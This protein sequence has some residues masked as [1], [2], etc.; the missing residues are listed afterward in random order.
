VPPAGDHALARRRVVGHGKVA[1]VVRAE[2]DQCDV[3]AQGGER[4]SLRR[5]EGVGG[6][7]TARRRARARTARRSD[8]RRAKRC[9]AIASTIES[10][11]SPT[12]TPAATAALAGAGGPAAQTDAASAAHAP[13]RRAWQ[14]EAA[15]I[16]IDGGTPAARLH[17]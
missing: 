12:R 8:R 9:D 15:S 14:T 3:E 16:L 1:L 7:G 17:P 5:R 10:P 13:A 11:V 2:Q 6:G 4:L